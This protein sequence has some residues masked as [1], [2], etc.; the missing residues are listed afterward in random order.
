MSKFNMDQLNGVI[1]SVV[2]MSVKDQGF[3]SLIRSKQILG[4]SL[5]QIQSNLNLKGS[6]GC[7]LYSGSV[8]M[9]CS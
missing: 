4:Y 6:L 9:H 8:Y 2:A 1:V 7:P 3:K 5:Q